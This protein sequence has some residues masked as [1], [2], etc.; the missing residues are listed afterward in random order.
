M[1]R[2][3]VGLG[4]IGSL[5]GLDGYVSMSTYVHFVDL[6]YRVCLLLEKD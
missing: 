3:L 2:L 5:C 1:D 4:I 6:A